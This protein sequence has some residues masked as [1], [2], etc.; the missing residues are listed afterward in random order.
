M[1]PIADLFYP[2]HEQPH[3]E[4]LKRLFED[5]HA[6]FTA[7][8]SQLE[9]HTPD[10]I[11]CDGFYPHYF[12]QKLKILFIGRESRQISTFN[13]LELIFEAYRT[14]KKIGGRSLNVDKVHSRMLYMAYGLL[15]G[16]PE[17]KEIP[18]ADK[19]GDT[20]ARPKA[21]ALPS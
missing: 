7:G 10:D 2:D 18:Y 17:W 5:W 9:K 15:N 12:D 13:N 21:S 14:T 11:V 19:I 16:I 20:L 1:K 3:L 6:C 8:A 4:K